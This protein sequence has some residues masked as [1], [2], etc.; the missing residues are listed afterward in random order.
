MESLKHLGIIGFLDKLNTPYTCPQCGTGGKSRDE[1]KF[2]AE[3]GLCPTCDKIKHEQ[4]E[5]A[6]DEEYEMA[7]MD[8]GDQTNEKYYD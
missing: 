8:S 4:M 1:R 7:K 5:T 3:I 2:I 6:I